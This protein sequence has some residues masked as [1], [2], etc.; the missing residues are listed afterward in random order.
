M[1]MNC[2]SKPEGYRVIIES[3]QNLRKINQ[4]DRHSGR[5]IYRM[6][7]FLISKT[8]LSLFVSQSLI[9]FFQLFVDYTAAYQQQVTG[10]MVH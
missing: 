7:L 3:F 10:H 2:V 6:S 4:R 5:Q 1:K 9:H 8:Q